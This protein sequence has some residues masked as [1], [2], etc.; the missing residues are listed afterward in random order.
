MGRAIPAPARLGSSPSLKGRVR[1]GADWRL[2]T[3]VNGMVAF[4]PRCRRRSWVSG[5]GLVSACPHRAA[6]MAPEGSRIS[7]SEWLPR[8]GYFF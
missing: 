5:D 7:S 6:G 8:G 2:L 3:E 4:A 1:S